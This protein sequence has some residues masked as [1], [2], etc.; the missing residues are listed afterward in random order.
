MNNLYENQY[1][2]NVL[3]IRSMAQ[4]KKGMILI[5]HLEGNDNDKKQDACLV[6]IIIDYKH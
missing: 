6:C 2:V 5:N 3:T 1:Q 4:E